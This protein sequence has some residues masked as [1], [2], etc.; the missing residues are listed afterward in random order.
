MHAT[1]KLLLLAIVAV[2]VLARAQAI[3]D[4]MG[5]SRETGIQ[6][7]VPAPQA[8]DR[9]ASGG[10]RL[11]DEDAFLVKPEAEHDA[12]AELFDPFA[13]DEYAKSSKPARQKKIPYLEIAKKES[14]AQGVDLHFVL[15]VIQ[16]ESSFDPKAHNKKSG[17]VGLMQVLPSTAKCLGLKDAGTLWD[18]AVN[19][20]YGVKYLKIL[21]REFGSDT[22]LTTGPCKPESVAFERTLA[23][24]NAG[25]GNVRKYHGV[26]PFKETRTYIVKI[27]E[28]F[29]AFEELVKD[30]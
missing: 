22:P 5:S 30:L 1:Q 28:F 13:G 23:A 27:A 26:P 17:A 14:A 29:G 15:A 20:K 12:D 4:L 9:S 3:D 8:V 24:Y 25:P 16:K 19:I 10:I 2:P 21:W 6:A 18:P 7:P 11:P